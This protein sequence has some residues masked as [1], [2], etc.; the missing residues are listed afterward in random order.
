MMLKAISQVLWQ[1]VRERKRESSATVTDKYVFS[2][3]Q[4]Y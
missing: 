2:A 3:V 4:P 1:L